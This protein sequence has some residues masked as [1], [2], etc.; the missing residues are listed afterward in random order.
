M[1]WQL[2]GS[3]FNLWRSDIAVRTRAH[4]CMVQHPTSGEGS[5]WISHSTGVDAVGILACSI[6]RA[7]FIWGTSNFKWLRWWSCWGWQNIF[8]DNMLHKE[9]THALT[10]L[11][12]C[13][14]IVTEVV[15]QALALGHMVLCNTDGI[16]T[17]SLEATCILAA[18]LMTDLGVI[19]FLMHLALGL[20]L[21]CKKKKYSWKNPVKTNPRTNYLV[22]NGSGW[23][24]QNQ[25]GKN[26]PQHVC[27]HNPLWQ[28][29]ASLPGKDS[30]WRRGSHNVHQCRTSCRDSPCQPGT[31]GSL[32]G[33]L[34][35]SGRGSQ[36]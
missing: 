10:C 33:M 30:L 23:Q 18:S 1:S 3:A 6:I 32:V 26:M 11:T 24:L 25:L 12:S 16:Q 4:G 21:N 22:H 13:I 14:W 29:I 28:Y 34:K 7:I 15:W 2:T 35:S 17:T 36:A 8:T 5:T 20:N 31:P 9:T 19:T 27:H